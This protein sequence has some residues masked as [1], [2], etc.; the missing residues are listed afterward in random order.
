MKQKHLGLLRIQKK[1][2]K[3]HRLKIIADLIEEYRLVNNK[4]N[5]VGKLGTSII[6][7]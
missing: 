7:Y 6:I 1:D 3:S 5:F 4:R 2:L